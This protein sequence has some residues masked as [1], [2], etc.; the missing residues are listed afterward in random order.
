MTDEGAAISL[1]LL[2][3]QR[4]HMLFVLSDAIP[5]RKTAFLEWYQGA[6]R[7]GLSGWDGLLGVQHYER[8]GVDI[9]QG[10]YPPLPFGYLGVCEVSVEGA[11]S[12]EALIEQITRLHR[13]Q[14]AA[15]APATWLYYPMSEKVGR[16]PSVLPCM[17]TLAFANSVPGREN[18]F[19]EWYVTRHI[20]HALNIPALV[21]GQCFERTQFQRPGAL[22]PV[23]NTIAVYEEEGPPES[24]IRCF[25]T[26]PKETFAF[27]MLDL[28]RFAEAVYRP[29]A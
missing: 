20:R 23:F 24:I 13:E 28:S 21:S 14:P 7:Q 19:R 6:Y 9:T 17:L 12:A 22:T 10:R 8:H 16:T 25:E 26:L 3:R 18:E 5:G 1:A 2:K 27:P 15:Q 4:S 29:L 11:E